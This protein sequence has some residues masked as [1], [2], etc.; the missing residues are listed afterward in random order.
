VS[1]DLAV[2]RQPALPSGGRREIRRARREERRRRARD[3]QI[4]ARLGELHHIRM[5]LEDAVTVVSAGWVQHGWFAVADDR[6]RPRLV[7][8]HNLHVAS[9]APVAAACLV[10]SIVHAG[11]GPSRVRSQ[12]VQR[13]LDLTWH[14]LYES[15]QEPVRWCPAPV[16]RA[17]HLRDLTRWNDDSDRTAGQVTELL[18][19]AIRT[20]EVQA[21]LLR[22]QRQSAVAGGGDS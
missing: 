11:G 17:A 7:T 1:V 13:A 22:H 18:R 15:Q 9:E 3:D 4:T 19:T 20:A 10:G 8:A 21:D 5:L 6:G 14:A 2:P 16:I 12:L